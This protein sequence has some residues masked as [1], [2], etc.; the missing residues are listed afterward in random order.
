MR[1]AG[2]G[3]PI[4]TFHAGFRMVSVGTLLADAA[5]GGAIAVALIWTLLPRIDRRD[6]GHVF[7]GE[8][9]LDSRRTWLTLLG[10]GVGSGASFVMV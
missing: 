4:E 2:W 9:V 8:K 7:R 6:A 1:V 3:S 10:A 5:P